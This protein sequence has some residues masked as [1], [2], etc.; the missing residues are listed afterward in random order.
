MDF[1]FWS[2]GAFKEVSEQTKDQ[3][4]PM[5]VAVRTACIWALYAADRLWANVKHGRVF[6]NRGDDPGTK[7]THEMW[8]SWRQALSDAQAT[9]TEEDTKKLINKALAEMSRA[10][11]PKQGESEKGT[12]QD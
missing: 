12:N 8:D 9:C 11:A 3:Q 10:S 1:S 2:F 5:A 4:T 6:G 7:I